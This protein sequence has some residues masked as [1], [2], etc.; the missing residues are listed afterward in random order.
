VAIA[1]K[2]DRGGRR[3]IAAILLR[4]YNSVAEWL[5]ESAG[6]GRLS[7]GGNGGDADAG[8]QWAQG[9]NAGLRKDG[10]DEWFESF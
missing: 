10:R 7:N 9:A 2:R 5:P 1:R 8:G 3:L 4:W 6:E